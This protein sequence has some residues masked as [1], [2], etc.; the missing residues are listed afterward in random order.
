MRAPSSFLVLTLGVGLGLIARVVS[1]GRADP[2]LRGRA[3]ALVHQARDPA[4]MG[5][6]ELRTLPGLGRGLATAV[7]AARA[8]PGGVHWQDVPGIGPVRS[9]DLRAWARA[10]GLTPEPLREDCATDCPLC[11]P[12]PASGR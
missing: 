10:R 3:R 7:L 9:A 2:A 8:A 6:R 12:A 11:A 1:G 4:R 5:A